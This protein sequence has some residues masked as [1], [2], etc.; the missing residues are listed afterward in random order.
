MRI[1]ISSI[2]QSHNTFERKVGWHSTSGAF[3]GSR[4]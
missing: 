4:R 3:M 2:K 1:N